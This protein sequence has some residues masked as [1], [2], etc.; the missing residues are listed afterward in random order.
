MQLGRACVHSGPGQQIVSTTDD[1]IFEGYVFQ[2]GGGM[3][4]G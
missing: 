4:Q 2:R 3:V 1:W